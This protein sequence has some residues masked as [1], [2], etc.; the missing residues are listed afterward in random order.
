MCKNEPVDI[1]LAVDFNVSQLSAVTCSQL[2][3][4][5]VNTTIINLLAN[6]ANLVAQAGGKLLTCD[7][8]IINCTEMVC[9]VTIIAL[10]V[11][12]SVYIGRKSEQ[13]CS[14]C[15]VEVNIST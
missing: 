1:V 11:Y 8:P 13:Y 5:Q 4:S 15:I 10:W 12:I 3:F 6:G 14:Q 7:Y 9:I 2:N